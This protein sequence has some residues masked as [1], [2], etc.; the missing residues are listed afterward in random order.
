LRFDLTLIYS[1]KK[2]T[3]NAKADSFREKVNRTVNQFWFIAFMVL[4]KHGRGDYL[5]AAHLSLELCQLI[6]VLQMLARDNAKN[7]EI[8]RFGD[9]E[10]I[11][12]LHGLLEL[13]SICGLSKKDSGDEIIGILFY[14]AE[15]MDNML[16]HWITDTKY[17]SG[18]LKRLQSYFIQ[19][20]G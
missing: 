7:T 9:K 20:S 14:A 3:V 12:V 16:K 6:V 13:K 5:I 8:H 15:Q 4:V 18:K 10:D 2:P 11:P 1:E 17:N 19:R